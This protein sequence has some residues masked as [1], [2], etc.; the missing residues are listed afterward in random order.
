MILREKLRDNKIYAWIARVIITVILATLIAP[1]VSGLKVSAADSTPGETADILSKV[2]GKAV[3]NAYILEV[4]TGATAGD[5][6]DFAII[7]YKNSSNQVKKQYIFPTM[8]SLSLGYQEVANYG[9]EDT[10]LDTISKK[11]GYRPKTSYKNATGLRAYKTDQYYFTLS[12]SISSVQSID[13]YA[14]N[15]GAWSCLAIRLFKVDEVYG[16]KMAGVWSSEY[17]IDFK[18]SL[19]YAMIDNGRTSW[20]PKGAEMLHMDEY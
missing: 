1:S 14:N 3:K 13:F 4:S 19:I 15:G 7:R 16:L 20:D 2:S 5:S 17:Y 10:V 11:T 8:D 12:D 18:G 9:N 6:I